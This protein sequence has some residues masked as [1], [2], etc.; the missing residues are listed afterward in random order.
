MKHSTNWKSSTKPKNQRKYRF[1]APL[2]L[3]GNFLKAHLSDELSKKFDKRNFRLKTGDKIKVMK[4]IFAGKTGKV[5]KIDTKKVKAYIEGIEIKKIDGTKVRVSI[6][7][8]NLMITELNLKD[9]KR[10]EILKR[11]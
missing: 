11:K 3:R 6:A 4:G 10:T 5:E 9:K 7:I 2:H 8:P 1:N